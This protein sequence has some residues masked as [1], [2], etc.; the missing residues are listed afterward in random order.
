M[1]WEWDGT[2]ERIHT[3]LRGDARTRR[4]RKRPLGRDHRQP[5]AKAAQK[6][7]ASTPGF[8]AARR[9][10]RSATFSSTRSPLAERRSATRPMCRIATAPIVL[11]Q[12]TRCSFPSSS[13]SS[14]DRRLPGTEGG[15]SIAKTGRLDADEIV[16]KTSCIAS[17]FFPTAGRRNSPSPGSVETAA[18]RATSRRYA[19]SPP[20]SSGLAMIRSCSDA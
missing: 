7:A 18:W 5:S 19:R 6:G 4:Q 16:S 10:G 13:A 3:N 14:A 11:D 9:Y 17:S 1:L 2:L 12:R 20:L 8:D 15:R